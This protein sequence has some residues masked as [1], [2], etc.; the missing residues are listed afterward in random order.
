MKNLKYFLLFVFI[1]L[2]IG[3]KK[4]KHNLHYDETL[5][6]TLS[7]K[8][9]CSLFNINK[10]I[11]IIDT[12]NFY[13]LRNQIE[14]SSYCKTNKS[15]ISFFESNQVSNKLLYYGVKIIKSNKFY[16]FSFEDKKSK[17]P[18]KITGFLVVNNKFSEKFTFIKVFES[19][20]EGAD[21]FR[22]FYSNNY[23]LLLKAHDE[24]Y[25]VLDEKYTEKVDENYCV[26]KIEANGD[27]VLL[28]ENESE[29]KLKKEFM[30]LFD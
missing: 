5:V 7:F 19:E 15:L 14:T 22:S 27:L 21:F 10:N 8:L 6:D 25:D 12:L 26:L 2:L 17:P 18:Y 1:G 9:N 3:C 29:E 4:I 23:L 20:I 30:N 16:L 13:K 24:S 28:K 11:E